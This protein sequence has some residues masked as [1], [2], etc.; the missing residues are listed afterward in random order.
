[1]C[2]AWNSAHGDTCD[3][4]HWLL[5]DGE[6]HKSKRCLGC[7]QPLGALGASCV[8]NL[9]REEPY[10]GGHSEEGGN[11]G[12]RGAEPRLDEAGSTGRGLSFI[13]GLV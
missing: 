2:V 6:S 9:P 12:S 11:A 7:P 10:R 8:E 3:G 4:L 13:L 1:M 5:A